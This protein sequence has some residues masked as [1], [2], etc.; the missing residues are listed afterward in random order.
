MKEIVDASPEDH[1][2]LW[3]DQE[4]ERHEI[5]RVLPESVDIY[6]SQDYDL[7]ERRV[8]DFSEGRTRLFATKKSLSGS[9]CNFQRHCHRE[10]FVGIDYEFNDFIQAIHRCY[11]FLQKEPVII[12]IIYMENEKQI[13]E[14]LL[15]K[16]KDHNHMVEKMI[17][18]VKKYG[19]SADRQGNCLKT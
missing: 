18:I 12:D 5:R 8:I 19:L 4:A 7:R 9:G 6:G 3:H 10:I 16:W 15:R 14:T 1:F 13:K 11:R 2:V 17:E